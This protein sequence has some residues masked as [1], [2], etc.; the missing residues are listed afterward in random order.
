MLTL[1]NAAIA[2]LVVIALGYIFKSKHSWALIML[3]ILL[4]GSWLFLRG[5]A[6]LLNPLSGDTL[7]ATVKASP[8]RGIDHTMAV[9][10]SYPD[11][12][13]EAYE[14]SG[15]RWG[16]YG[17]VIAY[18]PILNALG[19]HNGY[20]LDALTSQY[21]DDQAHSIKP[22][23]LGSSQQATAIPFIELSHYRVGVIEPDDGQTYKCIVTPQGQMY[24][25]NS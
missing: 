23:K 11:G 18:Q 5:S 15:D 8:V 16:L 19:L 1:Q 14:L 10:I 3:C 22:V 4:G 20:S 24:A 17:D 12:R 13:H 2:M 9:E 6:S 25:V 7:V 21:N